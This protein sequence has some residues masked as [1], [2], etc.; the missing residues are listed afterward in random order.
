MP[1][2]RLEKVSKRFGEVR[3]LREIDLEIAD[4]SFTVL[5]GPSGCGKTTTLRLVAG[6]ETVSSGRILIGERDVTALEPRERNVA[7]VFQNYALY[8]HMTVYDNIAFGLRAKKMDETEIRRRIL[9]VAAMLGLGDLLARRPGELSG[10]QQQRVAIGR[11]I[12]REPNLFLFDE[13]LS[14]LDAK[15]R[16]GMRTE[17]LKLHR[18]LGTTTIYVTHDQEE[19]MT[20]GDRI[21]VME[22]GEIRQ[23]G[24][25]REIYFRPADLMVARFVGSPPMNVLEGR[26]E[27]GAFEGA[28]LRLPLPGIGNITGRI[29]LGVRPEDIHLAGTL[30]PER[31]SAPFSARV[32]VIELLGARAIVTFALGDTEIKA[33]VEERQLDTLGEGTDA[34]LVLDHHRLHLFDAESGERVL[35]ARQARAFRT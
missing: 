24:T 14:N 10:G 20:M 21:V 6:L 9:D 29:L 16:I 26:I 28:G 23:T 33:V 12:V 15:L 19:A 27:G 3:T 30:E 32:E 17:L 4:G 18:E 11:A 35:G 22:A 5:V 34:S 25:P 1:G 31:A 7:M 2:V 13:P 8:P